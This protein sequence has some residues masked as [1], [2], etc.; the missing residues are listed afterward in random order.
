MKQS[1]AAFR[2]PLCGFWVWH[3]L[4]AWRKQEPLSAR[5]ESGNLAPLARFPRECGSRW[6]PAFGFRRARQA[7]C[8]NG[9]SSLRRRRF[10]SGGKVG[11][12][13]LDFHFS[14]AHSFSSAL[15]A[16]FIYRFSS[17]LMPSPVRAEGAV[18]F[19]PIPLGRNAGSSIPS[20][21][22][23]RDLPA[24]SRIVVT[25]PSNPSPAWSTFSLRVPTP[26]TAAS[27]PPPP[28]EMSLAS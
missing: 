4:L 16:K 8:V 28:S 20:P 26:G 5:W 7:F 11:I 13:P 24:G 22:S 17:C 12:L 10:P 2:P 18:V 9:I 23:V 21:F 25:L 1:D 14:T 3:L 19:C 27:W 6:K 15:F